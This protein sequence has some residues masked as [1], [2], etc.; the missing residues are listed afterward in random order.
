I[1]FPGFDTIVWVMMFLVM[2]ATV[3]SKNKISLKA[4]AIVFLG[5]IYIGIGFQYMTFTR[6]EHGLF[7]SYLLF[8]C[9]W[10]TDIGAYFTGYA[11]GKRPLW[12]AIS[13]KKTIEGALGGILFSVAAAVVFSFYAP[14][15]LELA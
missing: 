1:H 4:A 11:F 2:F 13:P 7:W 14:E 12:P 3:W 6:L 5:V 8:I 10:L 15:Q 9:I